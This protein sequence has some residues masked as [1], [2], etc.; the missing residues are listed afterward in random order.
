M[1]CFGWTFR[2]FQSTV[3]ASKSGGKETAQESRLQ[4]QEQDARECSHATDKL[5]S[6][7]PLGDE[8]GQVRMG[9]E[10][11]LLA[12]VLRQL[13]GRKRILPGSKQHLRAS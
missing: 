10:L 4:M 13:V 7:I 5:Y 8:L 6:V 9:R 1:L 12:D 3:W 11:I 2:R